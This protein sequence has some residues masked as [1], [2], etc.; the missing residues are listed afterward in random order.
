MTTLHAEPG[1][2]A[3]IDAAAG[4]GMAPAAL[5][6]APHG[7]HQFAVDDLEL[8]HLTTRDEIREVLHLRENIDLS[9][10]AAAGGGFE[11]LEKKETS[12]VSWAPSC[13]MALRSAPSG[14][15]RWTA[16]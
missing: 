5:A 14:S 9:V 11:A 13:S 4:S 16:A 12:A 7:R 6:A 1:I 3:R 10:H 15:F 2:R 8:Q